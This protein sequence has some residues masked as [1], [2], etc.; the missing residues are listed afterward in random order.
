VMV[1]YRGNESVIERAVRLALRQTSAEELATVTT[2][3]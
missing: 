2:L 1:I 3:E